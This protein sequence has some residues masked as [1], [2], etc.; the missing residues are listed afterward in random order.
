M[1]KLYQ[2]L[3]ED[4]RN[5]VRV[6]DVLERQVALYDSR[7]SQNTQEPDISLILD[8]MDYIQHYP[9]RFHHP[10]EEA[11]FDYLGQHGLGDKAAMQ[12]IR[13]EHETLAASASKLRTLLNSIRIG[14]PVALTRL[15]DALDHFHNQQ[16]AH[17][18]YE[19]RTVFRDI[20]A[21]DEDAS[22]HILEQIEHKTDPLFAQVASQQFSELIKALDRR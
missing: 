8:I 9:D 14:E 6:L 19:E 4:H 11:S 20:K 21:L 7:E 13:A 18:K 1:T 22:T 2:Q 16:L 5:L 12:T 3:R 17:L 15:H 10:L